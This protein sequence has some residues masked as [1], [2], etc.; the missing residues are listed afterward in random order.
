MLTLKNINNDK[1]TKNCNFLQKT[2][3]NIWKLIY[4][5]NKMFKS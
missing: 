2:I 3:D 4:N 1:N 5:T